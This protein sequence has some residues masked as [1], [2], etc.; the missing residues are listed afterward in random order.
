MK[1]FFVLVIVGLILV[2]FVHPI[3]GQWSQSLGW[4]GAGGGKRSQG[5][6]NNCLDHGSELREMVS[7]LVVVSGLSW[8]VLPELHV[9]ISV[10]ERFR[11]VVSG[12]EIGS[13][14]RVICTDQK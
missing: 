3:K 6:Q 4:G 14:N 12:V 7:K 2:N 13:R 5:V 1:S 10:E 9:I 8:F 11:Y